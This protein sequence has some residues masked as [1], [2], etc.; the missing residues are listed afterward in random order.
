MWYTPLGSRPASAEC[1][2][3]YIKLVQGERNE[4]YPEWGITSITGG[5][6]LARM[7]FSPF[8]RAVR[9]IPRFGVVLHTVLLPPHRYILDTPVLQ[10]LHFRCNRCI[11]RLY[12]SDI[13]K[14]DRLK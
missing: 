1:S 8:R 4:Q 12:V 6:R 2:Q 5:K 14:T 13:K 10:T 9:E 11:R 3:T 7:P